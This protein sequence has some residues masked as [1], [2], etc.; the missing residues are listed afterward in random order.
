MKKLFMF[1]L[2]AVITVMSSNAWGVSVY[3]AADCKN[4]GSGASNDIRTACA[5]TA[6]CVTANA[7]NSSYPYCFPINVGAYNDETQK[8]EVMSKYLL[9]FSSPTHCTNATG[10]L[11]SYKAATPVAY[12]SS[13]S[14]EQIVTFQNYA[15]FECCAGKG[16]Y[17]ATCQGYGYTSLSDGTYKGYAKTE[18]KKCNTDGTCGGTNSRFTCDKGYYSEKGLLYSERSNP[19]QASGEL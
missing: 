9:C 2:P 18:T 3:L 17:G 13:Y 8:D 15:Q 7:I 11:S 10:C 6:S 1:V 14:L 19:T 5:A 12:L 4:F 16:T